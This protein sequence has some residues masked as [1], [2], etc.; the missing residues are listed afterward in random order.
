MM[1]PGTILGAFPYSSDIQSFELGH[2]DGSSVEKSIGNFGGFL[3]TRQ[4]DSNEDLK[5]SAISRFARLDSRIQHSRSHCGWTSRISIFSRIQGWADF[6]CRLNF[7]L[8]QKAP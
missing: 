7:G 8:G 6:T 1:I 5:F 3:D 2:F 4:V